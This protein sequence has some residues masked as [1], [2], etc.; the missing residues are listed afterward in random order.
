MKNITIKKIDANIF[1]IREVFFQEHA[2]IFLFKNK[3]AGLLFDCGLGFENLKNILNELGIKHLTVCATHTHFD[4]SGG[5]KHFSPD[6]IILTPKQYGNIKNKKLW[7]LEYLNPNDFATALISHEKAVKFCA[8]FDQKIVRPN[9]IRGRLL[10]FGK[11][12]FKIVPAPGHTDDS[13]LFWEMNKRILISGDALYSG[14]PY[15]DMINSDPKQCLHTLR[16]ID[17]MNFKLLLPG[18]NSI[19]NKTTASAV[20]N[21]WERK[22]NDWLTVE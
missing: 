3:D 17:K 5:L 10:Q 21:K 7:G 4:H 11:Y 20:I 13:I 9:I 1:L 22:I 6:E 18:H 2:N 12:S 14:K 8:Q 19:L 15:L 16:N